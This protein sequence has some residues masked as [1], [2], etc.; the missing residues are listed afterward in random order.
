MRVGL[1]FGYQ[2]VTFGLSNKVQ[3]VARLNPTYQI[4]NQNVLH[5]HATM[6]T[7][8]VTLLMSREPERNLNRVMTKSHEALD[9]RPEVCNA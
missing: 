4:G 9:K 8:R 7:D 2:A 1:V 3:I 6:A 5:R